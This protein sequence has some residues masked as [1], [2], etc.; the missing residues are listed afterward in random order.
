M[1]GYVSSCPTLW[2]VFD[3]LPLSQSAT[4]PGTRKMGAER[5]EKKQADPHHT[6]VTLSVISARFV[7]YK[8]WEGEYFIVIHLG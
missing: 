3:M 6:S 2:S 7:I 1:A 5:G 8:A 4:E